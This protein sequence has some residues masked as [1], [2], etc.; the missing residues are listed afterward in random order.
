MKIFPKYYSRQSQK[1]NWYNLHRKIANLQIRIVRQLEKKN[2]RKVRNLQRLLIKSFGPQLLI[3]Q[4]MIGLNSVDKFNLYKKT[5]N[6]LFLNSLNL[7]NFIQSQSYGTF[8]RPPG[9]HN[10]SI[11]YKFLELLW[12]LAFIPINE[13]LSDPLSYNCRIYRTQVDIL[14]EF[15]KIY[16]FTNYKWLLIIK[17][18]GFFG[19][20]NEEWLK[21]NIL[22]E[23]KVLKLFLEEEKLALFN[24]KHYKKKEILETRKISLSKL[25]RSACFYG[26]SR[27]R[28]QNLPE[29]NFTKVSKNFFSHLPVVYYSD[30]IFIPGKNLITLKLIYR[31][32]FHFLK[33]RG[34][35]MKKDRIWVI[36][37]LYNF[38]FLGWSLKKENRKLKVTISR[39]NI[40]SHQIDLKKFLKSAKYMPIDK[41]IILLNRKIISWQNYYSYTPHIYRTW[42][43][44]NYYIFRL[45]WSWCK[46]RHKNKG[47][48]WVYNKYWFY[49]EKNKWVFHSNGHFLKKY[50]S[51]TLNLITLPG[52]VNACKI[53]LWET[54]HNILL[55]RFVAMKDS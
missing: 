4:K 42:S 45:V 40:R 34:L 35:L 49:N 46:K 24:R 48:K 50:E 29:L 30:I 23:K 27:F 3:S 37:L 17:P 36:N 13:T 5:R 53:K 39:E 26:F 2:F 22:L 16:H 47:T 44:M 32:I 1:V 11:Y 25:I 14:K 54:N 9:D 7:N 43:E 51:K 12:V 15:S 6:S 19:K 21:N 33:Q 38:N 52:S 31:M 8:R 10:G 41:V 20:R 55:F 28:K 18:T